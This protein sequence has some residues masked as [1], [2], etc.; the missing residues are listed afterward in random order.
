MAY[1]M[2]RPEAGMAGQALKTMG[3]M[4]GLG[5]RKNASRTKYGAK[6]NGPEIET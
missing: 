1:R 5:F 6:D 2:A 4:V 3:T